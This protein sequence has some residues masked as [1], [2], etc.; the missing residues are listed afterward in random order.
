MSATLQICVD[1]KEENSTP[2]FTD[3]LDI[4]RRGDAL[5]NVGERAAKCW[6]LDF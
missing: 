4:G 2:R 3:V 1:C 5:Q 6:A